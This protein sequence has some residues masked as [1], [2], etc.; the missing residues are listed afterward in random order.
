[1]PL[2]A[3]LDRLT[4]ADKALLGRDLVVGQSSVQHGHVGVAYAVLPRVLTRTPVRILL[5]PA[6]HPRRSQSAHTNADEGKD[7]V[8]DVRRERPKQ[9]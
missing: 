5:L 8:N 9:R 4:S 6:L 1:M 7:P 2:V 3:P